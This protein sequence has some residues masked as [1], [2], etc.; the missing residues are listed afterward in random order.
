ML[1]DECDFKIIFLK[2]H[3]LPSPLS[4]WLVVYGVPGGALHCPRQSVSTRIP[5]SLTVFPEGTTKFIVSLGHKEVDMKRIFCK[6][7]VNIEFT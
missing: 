3:A 5:L 7:S 1:F 2:S 6:T 4:T